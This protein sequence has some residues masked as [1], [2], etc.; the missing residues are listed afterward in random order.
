MDMTTS[1]LARFYTWL[2]LATHF[3]E[4]HPFVHPHVMASAHMSGIG[5]TDIS[6]VSGCGKDGMEC[7]MLPLSTP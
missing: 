6:I 3:P 2:L 1:V 5:D 7:Y 4:L